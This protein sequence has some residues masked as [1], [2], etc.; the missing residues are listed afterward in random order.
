M[1]GGDGKR[2]AGGGMG[3]E[4]RQGRPSR[5]GKNGVGVAYLR[6]SHAAVAIA[7]LVAV[8]PAAVVESRPRYFNCGPWTAG[9]SLPSAMGSPTY[10]EATANECESSP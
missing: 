6:T 2:R 1:P 8:G 10:N 5:T 7:L 9:D 4:K 3:R